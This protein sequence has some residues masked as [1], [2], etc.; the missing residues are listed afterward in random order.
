[1]QYYITGPVPVAVTAV[2]SLCTTRDW[3]L[4]QLSAP[5]TNF[6]TYT[7]HN[8]TAGVY[9]I[10]DTC[11]LSQ[12]SNDII[13]FD[14]LGPVSAAFTSQ[15]KWGCVMD[16]IVLSHPGGN[17]VNSWIWNF[18]DG[19]SA[20][21]QAVTK[22]YPVTD[23]SFDAELI[24]SN[25]FCSD[26]VINN[27]VLGNF[28][29]AGFSN[30]PVDSFCVNAPVIFTD[31]SS[32]AIS[33]YLWD[34][35]DLTQFNGQNPPAHMYTASN[36]FTIKLTVTDIHGC[37]NTASVTRFV[38]PVPYIDFTGLNPQYC[39]GN[40]VFLK[41]KIG[42]YITGYVWDNGDG[43][44]FTN[45][46]DVLFSY[47]NEGGYTITLSGVD[48]YCGTATVR[49]TVPVYKVPIV[50]LPADTV[51]C[52]NGQMLI[53]I[54]PVANYTYSWNT[55]A[56]TPQVLTGNFTRDYRLTADNHGCKGIDVMHVKV[57]TACLIKIPN[58]FTPNRD[59]LNDELLA[60]NADLA[61]DF[62][63]KVFNRSGQL[64]FSTT[65]PLEGWDGRFKGNP[66]ETGTYVWMLSYIDPWNGKFVKE[67]GTSIL[68]R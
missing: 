19:S 62:S 1:M 18:S 34:F 7:L 2:S 4:L 10:S 59:G 17:G 67:K 44:T 22:I 26:T 51:L 8:R 23:P 48:R 6:G 39:T 37:T 50:K 60:P 21:G 30:N 38:T 45:E 31:T 33:S 52:Q 25:G 11:G 20:S 16:T 9:T 13:S 12:N 65:N 49:K 5:I 53:G 36:N 27:I 64:V 41:R 63:F 66:Q 47:A 42:P 14:V 35:G 15:V 57:L 58:A 56:T 55:G 32:G 29:K 68:L 40:K 54:G 3:F 61:K 43:K 28:F 46:V 24:V